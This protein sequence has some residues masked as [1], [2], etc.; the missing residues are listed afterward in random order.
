MKLKVRQVIQIQYSKKQPIFYEIIVDTQIHFPKGCLT[1]YTPAIKR[2]GPYIIVFL[3]TF[4][5][6]FPIIQHPSFLNILEKNPY[7]E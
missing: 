1:P 2:L 6:L 5:I 3:C 4:Y 7:D